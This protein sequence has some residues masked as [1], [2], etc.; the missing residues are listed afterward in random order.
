MDE[1]AVEFLDE[2]NVPFFK[3]GS[4]DTNNFPYLKTT[5]EK[6]RPMLV[7]S[8]MQSMETMRRVYQTVK[9]H[10]P[11]FAILQCTSAYPLEAEDV[12]LRVLA[13]RRIDFYY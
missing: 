7:S 9:E 4:G 12:N 8:G 5:A 6:G 11:N 10:N 2:I 13:V 3:V 1:M